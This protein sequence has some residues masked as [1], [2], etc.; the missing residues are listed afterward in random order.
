MQFGAIAGCR[1]CQIMV[2]QDNA[3]MA[4]VC[5]IPYRSRQRKIFIERANIM[6]NEN[7]DIIQDLVKVRGERIGQPGKF[8]RE[9]PCI[10]FC[11]DRKNF[12]MTRVSHGNLNKG[13]TWISLFA[14]SRNNLNIM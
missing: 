5:E 8:R 4:I 9:M 10:Q 7:I 14:A 2:P 6:S 1:P 3:Q 13:D 11:L 12:W